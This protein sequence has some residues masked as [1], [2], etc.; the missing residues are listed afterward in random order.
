M[1][2]RCNYLDLAERLYVIGFTISP[3]GF[4]QFEEPIGSESA[5]VRIAQ[6]L[7]GWSGFRTGFYC[8]AFELDVS[9][10]HVDV[11][12][13]GSNCRSTVLD[14]LEALLENMDQVK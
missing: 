11:E 9:Q 2:S 5:P 14:A 13:S 3:A 6:G 7:R 8:V 10:V 4:E 1:C 12:R